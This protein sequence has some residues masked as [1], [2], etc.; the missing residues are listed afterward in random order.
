MWPRKR[1]KET[2]SRVALATS[3]ENLERT[4][5]RATDVTEITEALKQLRERNHFAEQLQS[6]MRGTR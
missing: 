6:I 3:I 4:K 5:D 2:E 1:K